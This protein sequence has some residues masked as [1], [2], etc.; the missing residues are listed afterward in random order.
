MT[1]KITR[2]ILRYHGSKW[3]LA[4]WV[5]SH[6]PEHRVYVEPFGGSG[7]I[8]L[9]KSRARTEVYNDLDDEC[10]NLFQVL[11]DQH[12]E[13][14]DAVALT[15][16]SRT[17][18][19]SLYELSEDPVERARRFIA[20]SIMGI[21]SKGGFFKSG[22]DTRINHD[23]YVSRINSL[24]ALPEE[25]RAMAV[26]LSRVIIENS[27]AVS[28]M[29]R[30]DSPHTLYYVDPPYVGK[31]DYFRHKM[32]DEQHAELAAVLRELKGAVIISGYHSPL[33]DDL[34]GHWRRFERDAYT[35]RNKSVVECLWVNEYCNELLTARQKDIFAHA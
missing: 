1:D 23:S 4:P 16:F 24:V 25:I 19:K 9:R 13:L 28:L 14:A 35:D 31:N 30:F 32:S 8:L 7:S 29:P 18:Y 15:P 6:F 11:R 27:D 33:Y 2:P 5:L 26:R 12:I 10:V 3:R 21:N 17:E 22:F 34:Y 20:R